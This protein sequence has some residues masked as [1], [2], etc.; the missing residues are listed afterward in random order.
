MLPGPDPSTREY[1]IAKRRHDIR[2]CTCRRARDNL[3]GF[4]NLPTGIFA[5]L[6]MVLF[7]VMWWVVTKVLAERAGLSKQITEVTGNLIR[8]SGWGSA[9]INGVAFNRCV[10]LAEYENGLLLR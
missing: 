3:S 4:M 10:K 7:P 2:R 8:E 1:V 5:L 9:K 6:F